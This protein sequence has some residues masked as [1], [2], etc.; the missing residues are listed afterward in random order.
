M[1][2]RVTLLVPYTSNKTFCESTGGMGEA[3]A[4]AYDTQHDICMCCI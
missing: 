2:G 1:K 3:Q 4:L